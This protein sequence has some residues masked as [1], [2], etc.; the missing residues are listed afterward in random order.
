[1]E[2]YVDFCLQP[3]G[4]YNCGVVIFT[5]DLR[6]EDNY[7]LEI[8]RQTC[9]KIIPIFQFRDK[10]INDEKNKYFSHSCVKFMCECLDELYESCDK[11]LTYYYDDFPNPDSFDAIF[12]AKDYTDYAIN[13][14]E[15]KLCD[16]AKANN[17][18]L[19]IIHNHLLDIPLTV[20]PGNKGVAYT[21][22]TPF[23]NAFI[24][25]YKCEGVVPS[26]KAVSQF[27]KGQ[28]NKNYIS[29]KNIHQF[30]MMMHHWILFQGAHKQK[31]FYPQLQIFAITKKHAI[32]LSL[33]M[34]RQG[35]LHIINL[36]VYRQE[37]YFLQLNKNYHCA[38]I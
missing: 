12:I 5:R 37:K 7:V 15:K 24:A 8:A 22:F 1:M 18:N 26:Y 2:K 25:H 19:I 27:I 29:P 10:Q 9:N 21:K 34:E 13:Y 36:D 20:T 11:K 4:E 28:S 14:R 16:Y 31:K 6:I 23:Y 30:T 17:K 32:F 38:T 35:F 33:K 3:I